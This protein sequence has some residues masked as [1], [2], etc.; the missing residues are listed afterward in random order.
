VSGAL[1]GPLAGGFL[2]DHWGLRTVFF[3]TAA[4]L[5]I[6]F[7]TLFLIRKFCADRQK[8]DAQRQRGF[9]RCRI[10]NWCSACL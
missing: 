6:C 1:L 8:R 5:F 2:A 7:L 4:V 9:L 10:P 3:M